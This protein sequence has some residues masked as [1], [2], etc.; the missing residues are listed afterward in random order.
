MLLAPQSATS[1]PVWLP[2]MGASILFAPI[3]RAMMRRARRAALL[4][5]G[6]DEHGPELAETDAVANLED[7]GD[8]L[9]HA[10]IMAGVRD[11]RDV[12]VQRLDDGEPSLDDEGAT[13]FDPLPFTAENLA[14][15]LADP[16]TFDAFDAAYVVPFAR[17]EREKNV[18]AALPNGTGEA[19][20][21][22]TNIAATAATRIVSGDAM[23]APTEP[24]SRKRR[25]PKASGRS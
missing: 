19:A 6:R 23:P 2:V 13:I 22:A 15:L 1:E 10:L 20:T 21:T 9:S 3:D 16:V 12:A 14:R 24:A 18:S 17:R 8:A 7:I 4:L 11:W 5:V 25:K